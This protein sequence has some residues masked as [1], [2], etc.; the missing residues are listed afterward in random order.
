MEQN[1]AAHAVY[2]SSFPSDEWLQKYF[3]TDV[4]AAGKPH[5]HWDEISTTLYTELR[6]DF[7]TTL[8]YS[9]HRI[10][11]DMDGCDKGFSLVYVFK[12]G[13]PAEWI[14][15]VL[16]SYGLNTILPPEAFRELCGELI[17][18]YQAG[19]F[20]TDDWW[21]WRTEDNSIWVEIRP[22]ALVNGRIKRRT[23]ADLLETKDDPS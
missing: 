11:K 17:A 22:E 21:E 13:T 12:D 20:F 1:K 10:L 5:P 4:A 15:S 18:H 19:A 7:D 16:E 3:G 2:K 6:H 8:A 9:P 14:D 23:L